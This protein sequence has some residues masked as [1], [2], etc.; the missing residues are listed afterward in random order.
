MVHA[1]CPLVGGP[2]SS[3]QPSA[4]PGTG[5][6]AVVAAAAL[7]IV[8]VLP[9]FL[10]GG[11]AVA[12][13]EELP[14]DDWRLGTLV[15]TY[16][17]ASALSSLPGGYLAE[18]IGLRAAVT[19]AAGCSAAALL[20]TALAATAVSHLYVAL[21]VAG[22][23]NGI[24]QP[25]SNVVLARGVPRRRQG[26]AFGAKQAAI[27]A[28]TMLAGGAVA[29]LAGLVGWRWSFGGWAVMA[30]VVV[31]ALP[32]GLR[33]VQSRRPGTRLREGDVPIGPML[34][35]ALAAGLGAAVGTSLA[36]FFVTAVV[37]TG[38][39]SSTA[40]GLL[41]LASASGVLS[42][43]VIGAA[44]DRM[45]GGHFRLV[46]RLAILGSVGFAGLALSGPFGVVVAA[47]FL[48]FGAGW[49]W[50][51]LFNYGVVR[52]N[53]NAPGAATAITQVGVFV[54]GVVGP[55]AFGAVAGRWSY[56]IAWL[57]SAVL[58]LVCAGVVEA[59]RRALSAERRRSAAG[60]AEH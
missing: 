51:G 29:V 37:S 18:R 50:P 22:I 33:P 57:G 58:S 30:L 28:A 45:V 60:R 39:G 52:W 11:L 4:T 24:A 19:V 35:L 21:A 40:G 56:P 54:G 55:L 23:G 12:I 59:A 34:L 15:A 16:F 25:T 20:G 53:P 42:R 47:S 38:I 41:T 14:L 32:K 1:P 13:R 27:P 2:A 48:A 5:R 31:L 43:L 17:L 7:S 6:R 36:S 44:A 46:L 49:G 10:L 3:T 26:L 8:G 9:V